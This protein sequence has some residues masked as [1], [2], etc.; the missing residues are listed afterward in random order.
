MSRATI[1]NKGLR[2]VLALDLS[3]L[4]FIGDAANAATLIFCEAKYEGA[5]LGTENATSFI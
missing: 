4:L 3:P 5:L 1:N 2:R